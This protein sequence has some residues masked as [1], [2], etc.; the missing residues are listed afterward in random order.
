MRGALL[1]VCF[2]LSACGGGG[3]DEEVPAPFVQA[4]AAE[5]PTTITPPVA[6]P[7]AVPDVAACTPGPAL[8]PQ[9]VAARAKLTHWHSGP[10]AGKAIAWVGDSTTWQL[11]TVPANLA[12]LTTTYQAAGKPLSGVDMQWFGANGNTLANFVSNQW[13]EIAV[14]AVIAAHPDLIVFSYGINDVRQGGTGEAAL[15]AYVRQAVQA[16]RSALP[17]TD[18]VLRMP[19]SFLTTDVSARGFVMPNSAAQAYTDILRNS[20]RALANEWPNV[21][22]YDSQALLF[23]ETSPPASPLMADQIHPSA[24]GYA[25]AIDQIAEL[26]SPAPAGQCR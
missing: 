16:F 18:I 8:A 25:R 14:H 20:Y 24:A 1:A 17:N 5:A 4:P 13:P 12:Y 3:G 19:S 6:A 23:G 9:Q 2:V 15:T 10:V 22:L 21:A 7:V 26:V 11:Q